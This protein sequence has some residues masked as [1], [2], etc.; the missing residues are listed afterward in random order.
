MVKCLRKLAKALTQKGH[1][2]GLEI[3]SNAKVPIIKTS[4]VG[5]GS[6]GGGSSLAYPPL[7]ADISIGVANGAAAVAMVRRAVIDLPPLRPL[8]LALKSLLRENSLNEVYQ[9]GLSSYSLVN[10]VIAHLQCE[11]FDASGVVRLAA[12]VSCG[13]EISGGRSSGLK[14]KKKERKKIRLKPGQPL[15]WVSG[16]DDDDNDED[17]EGLDGASP[18]LSGRIESRDPSTPLSASDSKSSMYELMDY[19]KGVAQMEHHGY[20]LGQLLTSFLHR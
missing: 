12:A 2:R 13:S 14:G 1:I 10:M 3:L 20:D 16:S 17:R 18:S 15:V 7:A 9:G 5:L 8:C 4:L 19:L 6:P 11:G